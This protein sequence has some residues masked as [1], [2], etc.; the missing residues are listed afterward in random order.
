M[1]VAPVVG[2][3]V[4]K[5]L[6]DHDVYVHWAEALVIINYPLC[7]SVLTSVPATYHV[8][9]CVRLDD[10]DEYMHWAMALMEEV[11]AIRGDYRN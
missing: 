9:Y 8:Y 5:R 7:Q 1:F 3:A 2:L 10:H 4:E 6:D 11:T